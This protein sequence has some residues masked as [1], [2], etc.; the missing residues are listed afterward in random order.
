[1]KVAIIGRNSYNRHGT[2]LK[3]LNSSGISSHGLLC[4]DQSNYPNILVGTVVNIA[5]P[6]SAVHSASCFEG[7]GWGGLTS[8]LK[9][10]PH[11]VGTLL[12]VCEFF[13]ADCAELLVGPVF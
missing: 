5:G 12:G 3:R 9:H 1:M 2:D 7:L 13:A 10:H 11:Q 8:A 4:G 6:A